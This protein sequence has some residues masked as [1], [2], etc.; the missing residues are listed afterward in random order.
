LPGDGN[1]WEILG[2]CP[3]METFGKFQGDQRG[4]PGERKQAADAS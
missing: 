2:R 4:C 3:A 1:I